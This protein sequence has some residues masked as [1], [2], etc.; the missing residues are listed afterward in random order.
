[1][2]A[3]M[4]PK[5]RLL[6]LVF[7]LLACS[8]ACGC[9]FVF[10]VDEGKP[11]E[12]ATPAAPVTPIYASTEELV[13]A[14]T[15]AD[16]GDE[17]WAGAWAALEQSANA[18]L[19][20]TPRSVVD[21]GP[22][23]DETDASKLAT[24]SPSQAETCDAAPDGGRADYCAALEM[25]RAARDLAIAYAMT[26]DDAY[27]TKAVE[28][29]HHWFVAPTTAMQA[30]VQNA[31]PKT[32]ANSSGS[33]IEIYL[34]VPTFTY[35][36]SFVRGHA[37]WEEMGADS[38]AV[39]ADWLSDYVALAR[40]R[41]ENGQGAPF[42]YWNTSLAAA[43]S[44]LERQDEVAAAITTWRSRMEDAVD[45]DGV[46]VDGGNTSSSWFILK[47]MTLTA[48]LAT[49]FEEDLYDSSL[50]NAFDAYAPC[51]MA[52]PEC[53]GTGDLD[54]VSLAEGASIYELAHGRYEDPAH[55]EVIETHGRPI[56]D[57]RI[58]GLTTLTH[59]DAFAR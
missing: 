19:D 23:V 46:I 48:Q 18:A 25:S 21:D 43:G 54:A 20:L 5:P 35:A 22:G 2:I 32:A 50:R 12:A 36:A 10:D 34:V 38:E 13:A 33:S 59:G 31:G 4:P 56:R 49:Y 29:L 1:M 14:K 39:F 30:A 27:A 7:G 28:L 17:P 55:L 26:G 52:A 16:A 44:Y 53:P 11:R 40:S 47:G 9:N 6:C 24:D 15:R 3:P 42:F 57:I 8:V 58:L 51:A 45:V 41:S 37:R